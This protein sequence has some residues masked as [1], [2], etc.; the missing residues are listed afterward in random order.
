M[1]KEK[2]PYDKYPLYHYMWKN[3]FMG[4]PANLLKISTLPYTCE[5][6]AEKHPESPLYHE[7]MALN[8]FLDAEPGSSAYK[9]QFQQRF[10]SPAALLQALRSKITDWMLEHP[11]DME[12]LC[13]QAAMELVA[14]AQGNAA[15]ARAWLMRIM[16]EV[17]DIEKFSCSRLWQ[18]AAQSCTL[19]NYL[20]VIDKEDQ[21]K[22]WVEADK[23]TLRDVIMAWVFVP[24][25][26]VVASITLAICSGEGYINA[27]YPLLGIVV[28]AVF[29]FT[30]FPR[31]FHKPLKI[32]LCATGIYAHYFGHL[33][34][35]EGNGMSLHT[36]IRL[37]LAQEFRNSIWNVDMSMW[38]LIIFAVVWLIIIAVYR[39]IRYIITR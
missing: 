15:S 8:A 34:V 11:N 4:N 10:S 20:G 35:T 18:V 16:T 23:I 3:A 28:I 25:P 12:I 24:Y 33:L 1:R 14:G 7:L 21:R 5:S 31:L 22:I 37:L 38:I 29:S 9:E 19:W 39:T 32:T 13:I 17:T 27:L 30:L 26:L 2:S 36:A 6:Y